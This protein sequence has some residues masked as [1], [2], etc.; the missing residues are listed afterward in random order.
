MVTRTVQ[1]LLAVVLLAFGAPLYAAPEKSTLPATEVEAADLAF[2][3]EE[4]KLARDTYLTFFERWDL[5]VF[6]NIAS[7]K[8]MHTDA[9]LKLLIHTNCLIRP[10]ARNWRVH[11]SKSAR[12]LLPTDQHGLGE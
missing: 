12:P 5:A 10:R 2:M 3:R 11:Q 9:I 1:M 6:S 4:E 7:S 8:Q